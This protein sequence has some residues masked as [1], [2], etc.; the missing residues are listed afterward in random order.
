MALWG[1]RRVPGVKEGLLP[2]FHVST[3]D[4]GYRAVAPTVSPPPDAE[5][6]VLR[7]AI[8]S[9]LVQDVISHDLRE[10][11]RPRTLH[12]GQAEASRFHLDLPLR[13]FRPSRRIL[14]Q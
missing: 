7:M 10:G 6:V 11:N 12:L 9:R 14:D 1:S 2:G 8:V 13:V 5:R 4:F 3:S